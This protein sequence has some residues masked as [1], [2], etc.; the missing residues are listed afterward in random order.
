MPVTTV[1]DTPFTSVEGWSPQNY[2]GTFSG[3]LTVREALAKSSN[4]A[5]IRVLENIGL[6]LTQAWLP[7][8]GFEIDK[9]PSNLTMALGTG[10][11]TPMQMSLAY[12]VFANGGYRVRP[13]LIEKITDGSDKVVFQ[14]PAPS[15]LNEKDRVLPARNAWVM[16]QLLNEVTATGTAASA[17]K[18]LGRSDLFGKTGTTDKSVDAWFVG[19]Q[20]EISTAVWLGHSKPSS[21]G[22][23]ETGGKAALPIWIGFMKSALRGVRV[24]SNPAPA[25]VLQD[26]GDWVYAQDPESAGDLKPI[27]WRRALNSGTPT[28]ITRPESAPDMNLKPSNPVVERTQNQT[29]IPPLNP[30]KKEPSTSAPATLL[31]SLIEGLQRE[32]PS[33]Q[34]PLES[35]DR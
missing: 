33:S 6:P 30:D 16:G 24:A 32:R 11:V 8:F 34:S 4:I 15:P 35:S 9:H 3:T 7:R 23:K 17:R 5:S 13:V 28:Q 25:G 22:E 14:A 18:I 1:E 27:A 19:Y 21:L 2:D 10:S 26:G 12:A 20:P 31:D 29:T